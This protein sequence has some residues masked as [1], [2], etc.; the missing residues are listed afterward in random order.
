MPCS[1]SARKTK[2]PMRPNPLIATFTAIFFLSFF[3]KMFIKTD[4]TMYRP[5]PH[6]QFG[7]LEQNCQTRTVFC[8]LAGAQNL[9]AWQ[10]RDCQKRLQPQLARQPENPE[11]MFQ[12]KIDDVQRSGLGGHSRHENGCKHG[13]L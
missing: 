5:P 13:S 1:T 4:G 2:R 9:P 8:A 12:S 7:S 6:R 3:N 11:A 10:L